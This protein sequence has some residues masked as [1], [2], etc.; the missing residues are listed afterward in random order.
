MRHKS[1]LQLRTP[2]RIQ[3]AHSIKATTCFPITGTFIL[4]LRERLATLDDRRSELRSRMLGR[5]AMPTRTQVGRALLR[6]LF[7]H[8]GVVKEYGAGQEVVSEL[9]DEFNLH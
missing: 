2:D 6:T 5:L 1:G 7:K 3:S 9:A 8:G 4:N